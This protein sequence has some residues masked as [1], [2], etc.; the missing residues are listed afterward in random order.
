MSWSSDS[1]EDEAISLFTG[2]LLNPDVSLNPLVLTDTY[3]T[4]MIS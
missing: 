1:S 4:L 2:F 3:I